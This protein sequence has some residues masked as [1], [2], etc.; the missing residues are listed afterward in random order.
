MTTQ[1]TK[2][3]PLVRYNHEPSAK[4]K[5][6][7]LKTSKDGEC[8]VWTGNVFKK[9]KGSKNTSIYPYMYFK[10][11][12]WRGNRLVLFLSTNEIPDN[13]YA[14][15]TCDNSL[16][17]N[18]RHLY[19]GTPKDNVEDAYNRKRARNCKVSH[20]PSGHPYSGENLRVY[21]G[22][23]FC[24]TC[25]WYKCRGLKVRSELKYGT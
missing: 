7:L 18:P 21:N 11:K 8:L 13:K 2:G 9:K 6:I 24:R 5:S 14:L 25:N 17:V 16:C 12:V 19:W 3:K 4:L 23:R 22:G 20:C 10:N 15:H 1:E